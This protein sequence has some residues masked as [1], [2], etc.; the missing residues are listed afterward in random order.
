MEYLIWF[1]RFMCIV[2]GIKS[3]CQPTGDV[4]LFFHLLLSSVFSQHYI[5]T[6]NKLFIIPNA[7]I[8]CLLYIFPLQFFVLVIFACISSFRGKLHSSRSLYISASTDMLLI[9]CESSATY[10]T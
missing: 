8:L 6:A 3:S 5:F 4:P 2:T 7:Y 1:I 10:Y 9:D